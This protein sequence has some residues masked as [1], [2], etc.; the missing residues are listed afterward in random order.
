MH[1]IP[2]S[3]HEVLAAGGVGAGGF[4]AP[5]PREVGLRAVRF[6]AP[7][8]VFERQR[9]A[10]KQARAFFAD[11]AGEKEGA[12]VLADAVVE[13]GMPALRLVVQ[14]FPAHENIQRGFADENGGEL[15]LEF[16]GR[17]EPYRCAGL[18]DFGVFGLLLNPVAEVAVGQLLQGGV[19]ERVDVDQGVEAVGA[20]VPEVPDERAVVEEFGVLGEKFVAQPVFEG[21]GLAAFE[22]GAGDQGSFVERTQRGVEE[23]AQAGGG[24]LFAV[25]RR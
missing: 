5:E 13:V 16:L 4:F 2:A 11:I 15:G 23:L 24:G 12:D 25:E 14:R 8:F 7:I 17:A 21:F 20:T 10:T 18:I 22:S 6:G 1:F 9:D 19:V 3:A